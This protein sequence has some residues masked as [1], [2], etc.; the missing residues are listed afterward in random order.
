MVQIIT[1]LQ[2]SVIT[3][4]LKLMTS[5]ILYLGSNT[6]YS[7]CK[8]FYASMKYLETLILNRNKSVFL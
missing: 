8:L 1:V 2:T 5:F 4:Y 3:C 7:T 6:G